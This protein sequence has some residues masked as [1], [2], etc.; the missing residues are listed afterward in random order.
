MLIEHRRNSTLSYVPASIRIAQNQLNSLEFS[1][2]RLIIEHNLISAD[3]QNDLRKSV[4][5]TTDAD[6]KNTGSPSSEN[7]QLR[8]FE[9]R[10]E[11]LK[12]I[13][14]RLRRMK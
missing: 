11:N 4:E 13:K 14:D 12:K 2:K 3:F 6:S 8:S 7:V 10:L 9:V 1:F 5:L